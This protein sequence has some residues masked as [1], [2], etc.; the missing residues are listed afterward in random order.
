VNKSYLTFCAASV[1]ALVSACGSPTETRT[2]SLSISVP[3]TGVSLAQG[4]SQNVTIT[5][6]QAN[7]AGPVAFAADGLPTGVSATFSSVAN[8]SSSMTLTAASTATPGP[9]TLTI[10]ATA[11]G[12]TEQAA[13]LSLTVSVTG[14]YALSATPSSLTIGQGASASSAVAITRL[15][16]FSGDVALTVQGAP[17]GLSFSFS[18]AS[19]MSAT[20]QLSASASA[21]PGTYTLTVDGSTAGLPNQTT[22]VGVTIV[23]I[24]PLSL[25]FCP[26]R[27]PVWLAYQN[28][29]AS[30]TRVLSSGD[31]FAFGATQK[32]SVMHVA[33]RAGGGYD[34]SLVLASAAELAA[35]ASP[36]CTASAGAKALSGSAS[37]LT[38]K[39][40]G[41][42]AMGRVV[43]TA[44][45]TS[46][47]F[48]L[49]GL[50]D[51]PL[52]LVA[53]RAA[54]DTPPGAFPRSIPSSLL[55][56][57][58]LN[59]ANGGAIPALDFQAGEAV[60]PV[61]HTLTIGG[62]SGGV[63]A[64]QIAGSFT[65]ALG[66]VSSIFWRQV[67]GS[68]TTTMYSVP[69]SALVT[70]DL[71]L[72]HGFVAPTNAEI[73]VRAYYHAGSDRNLSVGP[74]LSSSGCSHNAE[75]PYPLYHCTLGSQAEYDAAAQWAF[76]QPAASRSLTL[77]LTA[78]HFG[79][80]PTTWD[81]TVPALPASLGFDP[82]WMPVQ[83]QPL[84]YWVSAFSGRA[85]MQLGA[86][87]MDGDVVAYA[88][89]QGFWTP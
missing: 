13:A 66:T 64:G 73:G 55:L 5:V 69:A 33:A 82:N 62:A 42:V 70:G 37:G 1:V 10:R 76:D 57:R 75:T 30:W 85:V 54:V 43:D 26:D 56:R 51:G 25:R 16:G 88:R 81:V 65:S 71:H 28:D 60:S 50:P 47:A 19:A 17:A 24:T 67:P 48:A 41:I 59:L 6:T 3:A 31:T 23:Q 22:T 63:G 87:P 61:T 27:I 53:V 49:N 20:L 79:G 8:G 38:G 83:G 15:G 12:V 36:A 45:A 32:V 44:T 29:G 89:S 58:S 72:V 78:A 68:Q 40:T 11:P 7:L 46:A 74:S 34:V 35:I 39:E 80:R 2:P 77:T 21:A 86:S 84:T 9:A 14:T 18:G 52:D 4:A